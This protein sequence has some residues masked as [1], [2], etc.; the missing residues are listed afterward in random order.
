MSMNIKRIGQ[1]EGTHGILAYNRT[2]AKRL[3]GDIVM[4]DVLQTATE[5][6]GIT[7]GSESSVFANVVLPATAGLAFF[8]MY[9]CGEDIE[10]DAFG[11]LIGCGDVDAMCKDD[12]S[13]TTD[14]DA[15]DGV[16]VLNGD[17]DLEASATGNRILGIALE[18]A[19]ASGS[20]GDAAT[21]KVMWWG[22][23]WGA[24]HVSA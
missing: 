17:H 13:A 6:T 2:G 11:L 3:A 22:G 5:T 21:K 23:V 8:P 19:A 20:S 14:I 9:V 1:I 7:E 24:G 16:S 10:D 12:D 4:L 15:G 18:D